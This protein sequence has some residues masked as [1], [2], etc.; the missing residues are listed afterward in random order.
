MKAQRGVSVSF[1]AQA[2]TVRLDSMQLPA[3]IIERRGQL[4]QTWIFIAHAKGGKIDTEA[5]FF[6]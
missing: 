3:H 6:D 2:W 5:A 4:K 1:V